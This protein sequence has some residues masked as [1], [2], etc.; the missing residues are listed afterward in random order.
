MSTGTILLVLL[1]IL[2]LGGFS[3]RI[4]GPDLNFGTGCISALGV[5]LIIIVVLLATG[6]L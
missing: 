5:L 2:L 6:R 3:G 1:I 4:G